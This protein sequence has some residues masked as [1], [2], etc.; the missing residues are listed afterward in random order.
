MMKSDTSEIQ[1]IKC[2]FNYEQEGH[3]FGV[4]V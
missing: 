2:L 3:D 4:E 1:W